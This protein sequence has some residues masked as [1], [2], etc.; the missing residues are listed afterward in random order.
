MKTNFEILELNTIQLQL[1]NYCSSTLAKN[2]INHLSIFKDKEN[3][4]NELLKVNDTMKCINYYG[5]LPLGGLTDISHLLK[6]ANIDAILTGEELYQILNHLLCIENVI[7][8]YET[9][10]FE[11][12]YIEELFTGVMMHQGLYKQ[13]KKCILPDGS[14]SDHASETLY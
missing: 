11:V 4:E 3:L 10:E 8:Y 7:Q 5:R 9:I 13:I 6:K 14:I 1:N 2:K 12:K